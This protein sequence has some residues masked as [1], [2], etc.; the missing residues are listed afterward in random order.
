MSTK[1]STLLSIVLASISINQSIADPSNSLRSQLNMDLDQAKE[2]IMKSFAQ[3]LKNIK[4]SYN[5]CRGFNGKNIKFTDCFIDKPAKRG[6]TVNITVG[7]KAQTDLALKQ[8]H[9]VYKYFGIPLY[10][11]EF[12]NTD[13]YKANDTFNY[14]YQRDV[15]M[16]SPSGRIGV[17][18]HVQGQDNED[19]E[20]MK[21]SLCVTS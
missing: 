17:E 21:T 10:N 19:L 12:P 9:I 16:F 7:M 2:N 4:L 20:C 3:P 11:D 6:E 14:V 15:P 13:T 8:I 5:Y 18:A 1:I